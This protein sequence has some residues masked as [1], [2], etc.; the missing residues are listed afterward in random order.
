[1]IDMHIHTKYSDG[2]G[3]VKEVLQKAEEMKLEYIS[4][5]DHDN[6]SAYNELRDM[7]IEELY[8]GKIISNTLVI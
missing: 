8:S 3:T 1:M 2:T 6:C 7:N 4:I 5:T